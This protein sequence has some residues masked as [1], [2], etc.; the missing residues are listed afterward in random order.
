MRMHINKLVELVLDYEIV[1][2]VPSG[3]V[4]LEELDKV[5]TVIS[6]NG[7]KPLDF[8]STDFEYLS[9]KDKH[10]IGHYSVWE[11]GIVVDSDLFIKLCSE[12]YPKDQTN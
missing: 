3:L 7:N 4:D 12:L 6:A 5:S 9:I 10:L 2:Y 11:K 8:E 1:P